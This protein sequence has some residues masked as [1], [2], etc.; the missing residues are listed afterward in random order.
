MPSSPVL[1]FSCRV[2]CL[3]QKSRREVL[4]KQC[5]DVMPKTL[6]LSLSSSIQSGRE[7]QGQGEEDS[8][9][10]GQSQEEKRLLW[11]V[12]GQSISTQ[13]RFLGICAECL[14]P[15][16]VCGSRGCVSQDDVRLLR[17]QVPLVLQ[18]GHGRPSGEQVPQGPLQV[19]VQSAVEAHH[20]L[21]AGA[22]AS[23]ASDLV[24]GVQCVVLMAVLCVFCRNIWITSTR[25]RS[26]EWVRWTTTA[27]S[28]VRCSKSRIWREVRSLAQ[29]WIWAEACVF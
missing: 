12:R 5:W 8:A 17:L 19:S 26:S 3:T 10:C 25:R 28:S 1:S 21:P 29:T 18:R 6:Y 7:C 4:R 24:R 20:R 13:V 2:S 23:L 22:D 11:K 14:F 27:P 9:L 16:R 15:G